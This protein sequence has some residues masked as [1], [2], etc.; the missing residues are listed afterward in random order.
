[1][2]VNLLAFR[3]HRS[4]S[5][6]ARRVLDEPGGG[7]ALLGY[8]NLSPAKVLDLDLD[9]GLDLDRDLDPGLALARTTIHKASPITGAVSG[10]T[11]SSP[12]LA[13][14]GTGGG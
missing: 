12:A 5:L 13:W 14:W 7:R 1:M 8:T 11:G 10:E 4:C 3:G 2:M 6:Q 9:L